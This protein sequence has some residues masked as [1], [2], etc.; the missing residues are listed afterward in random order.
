MALLMDAKGLVLV[1]GSESLPLG[2][3][4]NVV[5]EK[6]NEGHKKIDIAMAASDD[7]LE[8]FDMFIYDVL[9]IITQILE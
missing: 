5:W 1:P 2:E 3:I 4:K 8:Y 9:S 7:F 6:S